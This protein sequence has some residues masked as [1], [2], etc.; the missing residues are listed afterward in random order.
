MATILHVAGLERTSSQFRH[1]LIE[2]TKARGLSADFLAAVMSFETG[3]T[4][5]P[6]IRNPQSGAVGLI[7]FA[8]ITAKELDVTLDELGAMGAVEQLDEV[9]R[10]FDVVIKK[11]VE[12][13]DDHALAVFAPAFIGKAPNA[14]AY[15]SPSQAYEQNKALDVD[16]D[17]N[18]TVSEYTGRVRRIVA[19]ALARPRLEVGGPADSVASSGN[20]GLLAL[21]GGLAFL[22]ASIRYEGGR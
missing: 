1:R 15:A 18:I 3:G 14:V 20:I 9:G 6:S 19:E 8:P 11:P 10:Y 5:S 4:F 17:G 12:S 13:L 2:V 21:L 7:Q 16:E 22:V